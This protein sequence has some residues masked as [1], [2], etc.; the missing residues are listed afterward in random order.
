M[1]RSSC[2]RLRAR[3]ARRRGFRH[4]S[5]RSEGKSGLRISATWSGTSSPGRSGACSVSGA[6]PAAGS[7]RLSNVRRC[8]LFR[9]EIQSSPAGARSARMRAV[10]S[11]PRWPTSAMR[12]MPK[13][14]R[15][16]CTCAATV[17]GSAVL[18]A[19]TSTASGQP[20]AAH[21]GAN[22][23]CCLPRLLSRL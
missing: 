16:R 7:G 18:P 8:W 21:S 15:M 5:R 9:A 12:L 23:I 4:T 13:R 1:A 2:S 10:V 17:A 3:S 22:T 20:S 11:M 19:N 14:W 6:C